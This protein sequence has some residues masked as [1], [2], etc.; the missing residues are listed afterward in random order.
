M[1]RWEKIEGFNYQISDQGRIRNKSNEILTPFTIKGGIKAVFLFNGTYH[2][3]TVSNLVATAFV[4]N[5]NSYKFVRHKDKNR[6]NLVYT[7]LEWTKPQGRR[8]LTEQEAHHIKNS[9]LSYKHLQEIYGVSKSTVQKI[10]SGS[11]W[12]KETA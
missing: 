2:L 5:P 1:E 9:K 7:N 12:R 11:I 6:S 10:K 8:K 3:R 4:E